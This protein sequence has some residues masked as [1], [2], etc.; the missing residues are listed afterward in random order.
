MRALLLVLSIIPV[1]GFA[2]VVSLVSLEK[3]GDGQIASVIL[4]GSGFGAKSVPI[5]YDQV[6][7]V[8][9]KG[10]LNSYFDSFPPDREITQK[11]TMGNTSSPW[12]NSYGALFIRS[13]P[14]LARGAATGK[15][16]NGIGVKVNLQ[17]PRVHS[18]SGT[19][20][21]V[22]KTYIS[23]WFRQQNETRNY[24][25][26]ELSDVDTEF[27]PSEGEE[28]V[29]DAGAH[30][31]GVTTIYG[32]VIAYYPA[33][34]TLHANFYG[35]YNTNRLTGN[36]LT[37]SSTNKSALLAVNTRGPGSNKYIRVWESDGTEG[38]FRLS[39]TNFS[40]H[41]ADFSVVNR[42]NVI[43]REWNFME[44]FIDQVK[45]HIKTKVNGLIDAEGSYSEPSDAA[46][47]SPTI[48]LIGQDVNQIEMHQEI[49]MDD[50]YLDGSFRRIVLGNAPKFSDVTHQEVQ[51]FSSWKNEEIRFKPYYGGL[52]RKK[53]AYIYIFSDDDIPNEAGIAFESPP[54]MDN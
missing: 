44:L 23:W 41:Q 38:T 40:V 51:F 29:V 15:Y 5:F 39:W 3:T 43:P 48:G 54:K 14:V 50:I 27:N 42:S 35:Q 25:Q 17:N 12:S 52:D 21:E 32:R 31:S 53:P 20:P 34:K 11:D 37:L 45:G 22:K 47:Y 19:S 10:L 13:D 30:W 18:R 4:K 36:R 1:L 16:Y 26:F 9:E 46:G 2:Q 6:G 24:F 49:W 33:T 28:F 8:Y 7:P